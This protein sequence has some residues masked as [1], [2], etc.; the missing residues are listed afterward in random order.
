MKLIVGLGNPGLNY[1]NTRHNIGFQLLDYIAKERKITF[2]RNKFN[3]KYVELLVNGEKVILLKPLSYMNCSGDVVC[4]FMAVYKISLG[5]LWVIHDDVDMDFGRV[6]VVYDSSSGGHNGIKDIE[7][8]LGSK[9]YTRLKI[10]IAKDKSTDVK[11]Y[12][13]SNFTDDERNILLLVDKNLVNII[14]DFCI[15]NTNELM[16]KYNRR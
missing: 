4:M 13:L 5:D 3:G 8:H 2:I 16:N 10:G 11:D 6:K 1:K 15:M 14:D 7:R 9:K 12:V